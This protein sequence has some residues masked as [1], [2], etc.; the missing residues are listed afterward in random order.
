MLILVKLFKGIIPQINQ[1][2][3]LMFCVR[4]KLQHIAKNNYLLRNYILEET[5]LKTKYILI[6]GS[7][8]NIRSIKAFFRPLLHV[9]GKFQTFINTFIVTNFAACGSSSKAT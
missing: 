4:N 7:K 9:S 1:L 5:P 3:L 8:K 6:D 2:L